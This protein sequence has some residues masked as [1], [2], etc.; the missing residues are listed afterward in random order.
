L[1]EDVRIMRYTTENT[2]GYSSEDLKTLN[3]IYE[4][5]IA[6]LDEDERGNPDLLQHISEQVLEH[7]DLA[8]DAVPDAI[9]VEGDGD[10]IQVSAIRDL[11]V[12]T[13]S[14]GEGYVTLALV[15]LNAGD[16]PGILLAIYPDGEILAQRDWQSPVESI[17][18]D[19]NEIQW[20]H[21]V[22][23]CGD[24][25]PRYLPGPW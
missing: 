24:G 21:N 20:P 14:E 9:Y 8:R 10:V 7:Y 18:P 23:V 19:L 25:L 12:K 1:G 2:E 15:D 13:L 3:R 11:R 4:H 6:L 5:R 22:A 17:P 16:L